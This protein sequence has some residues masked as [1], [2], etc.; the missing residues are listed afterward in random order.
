MTGVQTCALPIWARHLD[1]AVQVAQV[2]DRLV[3]RLVAGGREGAQLG[4]STNTTGTTS[5]NRQH[6]LVTHEVLRPRLKAVQQQNLV[7]QLFSNRRKVVILQ[8]A[9]QRREGSSHC[10]VMFSSEGRG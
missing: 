6:G 10:A 2:V 7:I 8:D 4:A 3:I 5:M 9:G 1:T